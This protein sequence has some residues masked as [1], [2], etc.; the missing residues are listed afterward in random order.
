[1]GPH[2]QE[3]TKP[4]SAVLPWGDI[5]LQQPYSQR[6]GCCKIWKTPF[7]LGQS[8]FVLGFSPPW[9][10]HPVWE[11]LTLTIHV[12]LFKQKLTN[13]GLSLLLNQTQHHRGY[14]ISQGKHHCLKRFSLQLVSNQES[15]VHHNSTAT[16]LSN[17]KDPKGKW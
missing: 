17:P 15:C 10:L 5:W 7:L 12:F 2:R 4:L 8:L 1:M 14:N 9:G 11:K 3:Q 13:I 16:W 6:V